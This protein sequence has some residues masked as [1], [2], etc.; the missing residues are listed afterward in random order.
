MTA[1]KPV[2]PCLSV[3]KRKY[4]LLEVEQD[5]TMK[6]AVKEAKRCLRCELETEDG[7]H[8]VQ[9]LKEGIR[10]EV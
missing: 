10:C 1:S 3:D 5:L 6:Q 2:M 8:F 7:K 9:E 4:N